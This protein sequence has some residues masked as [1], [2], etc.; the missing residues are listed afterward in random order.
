MLKISI[1]YYSDSSVYFDKIRHLD[2]PIF[3]DSSYQKNMAKN[4]LVRFDI[5]T[6]NP[7]IKV[8]LNANNE[9]TIHNLS[10]G[11]LQTVKENPVK[12]LEDIMKDYKIPLST[13][14]FSGGALG[15]F[16]Y[17]INNNQKKENLI[18]GM[19]FGIYDLSLIHI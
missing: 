4:K 9:T 12:I 10:N 6:A 17:D 2:W 13:L 11:T 8:I 1:P 19:Q 7:F 15:Y 14:P 16:S 18:P 5:L 3:L